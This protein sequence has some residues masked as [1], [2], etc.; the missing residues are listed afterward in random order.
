MRTDVVAL[1]ACADSPRSTGEGKSEYS[2][3]VLNCRNTRY[4]EASF[5]IPCGKN[6]VYTFH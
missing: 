1:E 3:P 2:R 4:K 6:G 5:S